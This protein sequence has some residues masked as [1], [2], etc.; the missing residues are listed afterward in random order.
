MS[1]RSEPAAALKPGMDITV[2][3]P[4]DAQVVRPRASGKLLTTAGNRGLALLRTEQVE[5][6]DR[7]IFTLIEDRSWRLNPFRPSHWPVPESE[8]QTSI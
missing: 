1:N 2:I 3:Q 5:K 4:G 8:E 7:L 6:S